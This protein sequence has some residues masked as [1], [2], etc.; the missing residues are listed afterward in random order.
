MK[1]ITAIL[2]IST[3][4]AMGLCSG[5]VSAQARA[6]KVADKQAQALTAKASAD[7][8]RQ[9][10]QTVVVKTD[11]DAAA[12]A[13][14][15]GKKVVLRKAAS[16]TWELTPDKAADPTN[17][18]TVALGQPNQDTSASPLVDIDSTTGEVTYAAAQSTEKGP[19]GAASAPVR[20]TLAETSRTWFGY[21]VLFFGC[22]L[23]WLAGEASWRKKILRAVVVGLVCL[24]LFVMV[25][26]CMASGGVK[27]GVNPN[28]PPANT[29]PANKLVQTA[30]NLPWLI[31]MSV[32]GI[33]GGITGAM[34]LPG[35]LKVFAIAL[36]AFCAIAMG[37]TIL[38]SQYAL[39]V[40]LGTAVLCLGVG[41]YAVVNAKKA[42][43]ELVK[44]VDLCKSKLQAEVKEHLFGNGNTLETPGLVRDKVQSPSTEAIVA[45]VRGKTA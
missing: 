16:N 27:P 6:A 1:T 11:A 4:L 22:A 41:A 34:F 37:L 15:D 39:Y 10:P 12:A 21:G 3:A 38:V 45:A 7:Q 13:A 26:G 5:C 8:Q 43:P 40:V 18:A 35:P 23:P 20:P 29:P 36:A 44:T 14:A 24:T 19:S 9:W 17:Q 28:T 2:L 30:L 31:T 32:L 25:S 33:S 42:I